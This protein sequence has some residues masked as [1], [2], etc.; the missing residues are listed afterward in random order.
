MGYWNGGEVQPGGLRV[1]RSNVGFGALAHR[2]RQRGTSGE[3]ALSSYL[4]LSR[5]VPRNSYTQIPTQPQ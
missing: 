2:H 4:A 1:V 5:P 3:K